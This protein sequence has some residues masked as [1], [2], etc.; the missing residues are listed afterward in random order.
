MTHAVAPLMMIPFATPTHHGKAEAPKMYRLRKCFAVVQFDVGV[1]GR[2][3]FLPQG[4]EVRI[5]GSSCLPECFEVAHE[6]QR[7]NIFKADLLSS[8]STPIESRPIKP[9][10]TE[11]R[12]IRRAR[13]LTAVRVCA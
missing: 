9:R 2:I 11:P 12:R 7:Y 8:W 6:G 4:A 5:V 3:V 1:R 10:P 13:T